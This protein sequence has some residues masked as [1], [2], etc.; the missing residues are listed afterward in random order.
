MGQPGRSVFWRFDAPGPRRAQSAPNL[1][2]F[3]V[4]VTMEKVSKSTG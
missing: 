4:E 2:L 3:R 1:P